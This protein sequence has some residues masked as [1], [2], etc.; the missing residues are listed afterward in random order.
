MKEEG[1]EGNKDKKREEGEE[2]ETAGTLG[3]EK[4]GLCFCST[5]RLH[6]H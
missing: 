5:Y 1:E 3:S 4:V 6:H 2:L